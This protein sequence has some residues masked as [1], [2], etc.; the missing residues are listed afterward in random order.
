MCFFR[1]KHTPH[2]GNGQTGGRGKFSTRDVQMCGH[3]IFWGAA[4][5]GAL[6]FVKKSAFFFKKASF[7]VGEIVMF[8]YFQRKFKYIEKAS[9]IIKNDAFITFFL[10]V[11]MKIS[12]SFMYF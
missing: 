10:K 5:G 6:F 8:L 7:F 12:K 1:K 9:K 2:L 11:K 4:E 3:A